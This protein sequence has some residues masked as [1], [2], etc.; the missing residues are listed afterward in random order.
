[1]TNVIELQVQESPP[2]I[3]DINTEILEQKVRNI[4]RNIQEQ[5]ISDSMPW[6]VAFSGGKDS[7]ATLQL[8]FTALAELPPER[9]NKEIHVL[10]NDT[11]VEN[12][13]VVEF[14]DTQLAKILEAGRTQLFAHQP[15]LFYV[16][17]TT[18]KLDDT[19]WL[20]LIG[21]GYPSPTRWFRWC[22]ERMKI[23]PTNE[24]ILETVSKHGQAIIILGTRRDESNNRAASIKQY[25]IPGVRLRSY[26]LPN[27]YVFAPISDITNEEVWRYL[28]DYPNPWGAD[29]QELV[30]LYYSAF[31][32]ME[33]PLVI[34][35]TTPS[36]GNSRFGCWV[37]T[38]VEKDRS[39]MG[40]VMNGERWMSPL[41]D[42]RDW[43]KQIR[44]DPVKRMDKRRNGQDGPGPFTI[45]ARKEILERVLELE[46]L[47][48]YEFISLPELSAIQIQW[49]YDGYFYY[50]VREIYECIKGKQIMISENLQAERRREEFEVLERVCAR[51]GVKPD[52]IKELMELERRQFRFLRR[53]TL[54]TDM[55]SKVEQFV[56]E[57]K[58]NK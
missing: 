5:Y 48:D 50:N 52:H 39:M 42:F 54:F 8:I 22:T 21:K 33:C 13:K 40:M 28:I 49:N 29:N 44:E 58:Q 31:D 25:E 7:T 9:L 34:D 4:K 14:L 2:K 35:K 36:C 37:C 18:P 6:V 56:A 47:V 23:N 57:Q 51:H 41:L 10:S 46:K 12:P 30:R 11:L 43:L 26:R 32:L 1:M 16:Q 24:Y 19:F 45:E 3:E 15:Q 38:V 53:G 55:K 17:K 27:S 20:N